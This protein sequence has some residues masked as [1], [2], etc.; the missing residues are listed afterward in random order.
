M[1]PMLISLLA[2]VAVAAVVGALAF[3]FRG[4]AT[5]TSTRLEVLVGTRR[6]EDGASADILRKTAFDA[7]KKSLLEAITP[8]IP[9]LEKFFEQAECHIRP[10]TLVGIGV[11]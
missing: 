6:T 8:K 2:F 4:N 10:A 3:V 1:T 9:S 7:D 11:A 5:D